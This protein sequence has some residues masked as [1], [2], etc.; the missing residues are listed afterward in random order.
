[1]ALQPWV[2]AP[3]WPDSARGKTPRSRP[4]LPRWLGRGPCPAPG[5]RLPCPPPGVARRPHVGRHGV[6]APLTAPPARGPPLQAFPRAHLMF[7]ATLPV[8]FHS[9]LCTSRPKQKYKGRKSIQNSSSSFY[10]CCSLGCPRFRF[11][12]DNYLPFR[13]LRNPEPRVWG[14]KR[15]RRPGRGPQDAR[16]HTPRTPCSHRLPRTPR[17]PAEAG[18]YLFNIFEYLSLLSADP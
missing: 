4:P 15:K 10:F 11:S 5:Q 2:P 1:M 13:G 14:A 17:E 12:S 16:K 3:A 9:C 8:P 7:F 6:E 18:F